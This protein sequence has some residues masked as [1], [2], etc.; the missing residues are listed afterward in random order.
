MT[1]KNIVYPV[2]L[3][4][5]IQEIKEQLVLVLNVKYDEMRMIFDGK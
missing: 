2:R 1:G 4:F 5:T 3:D